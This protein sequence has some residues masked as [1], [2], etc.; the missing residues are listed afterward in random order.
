MYHY[1]I[2]NDR[3]V[4]NIIALS[5]NMHSD[6]VAVHTHDNTIRL[7]SLHSS[8]S[9][10]IQDDTLTMTLKSPVT[11]VLALGIACILISTMG[12]RAGIGGPLFRRKKS[13]I[14]QAE[15]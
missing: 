6:I 12:K 7:T 15:K 1:A 11:W 8:L 13:K 14:I 2:E 5:S 9:Y 10:V 3:Q 4:S